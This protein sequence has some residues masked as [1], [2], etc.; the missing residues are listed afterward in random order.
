MAEQRYKKVCL[1]LAPR[2]IDLLK[3]VADDNGI[4]YN[5]LV[6]QALEEYVNSH[7]KPEALAHDAAS[8]G[9]H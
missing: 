4:G 1:R 6:R 2:L 5:E 9:A 7:A 3:S 8:V